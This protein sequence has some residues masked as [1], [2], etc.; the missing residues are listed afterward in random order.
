MARFNSWAFG[1]IL[2]LGAALRLWRLDANG[3]GT[4][5][6]AAGVRSMLESWHLFFFNAFDPAGFVTI[7][8]PPTA[9]WIQAASAWLF[10]Y[11]G[12]SLLLPQVVE[13]LLSIAILRHLVRRHFG[14][15]AGLLAALFL[16]LTPIAVAIDRSNNTDSALLLFLLLAAWAMLN[17][18]ERPSAW[19]VASAMALVGVAFNVKMLVALGVV[20][21]LGLAYLAAAPAVGR[22]G[23]D[24][25][26]RLQLRR[27][28]FPR[29]LPRGARPAPRRARRYRAGRAVVGALAIRLADCADAHRR[30]AGLRRLRP[31]DM[32]HR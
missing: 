8:K 10:G 26:R 28:H 27:R 22:L 19:R 23:A 11:S 16:A 20:P 5:Y 1:A 30:V 25:W 15:A 31:R 21:I 24:L 32:A 4:E 13:G 6:Y 3:F 14:E 18:I 29:L 2:L 12:L 7:D 17:A 9:F